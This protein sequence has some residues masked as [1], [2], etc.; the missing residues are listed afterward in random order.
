MKTTIYVLN[1]SNFNN[2]QPVELQQ[3]V[4]KVIQKMVLILV[5]KH[6]KVSDSLDTVGMGA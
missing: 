3:I 2:E 1:L 4:F 5:A 6:W